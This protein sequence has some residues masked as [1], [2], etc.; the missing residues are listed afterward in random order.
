MK[1]HIHK[2][3]TSISSITAA[4]FLAGIFGNPQAGKQIANAERKTCVPKSVPGDENW[5]VVNPG[6]VGADKTV[7]AVVSKGSNI[8]FGGSFSIIGNTFANN[9]VKWDGST[10]HALGS[11]V[12]CNVSPKADVCALACDNSGNIYAGGRFDIAG[13]ISANHVAKWNGSS[14]SP[15]GSG[16]AGPVTA[17]VCDNSGNLYTN[18]WFDTTGSAYNDYIAKWNGSTWSRLCNGLNDYSYVYALAID[19]S[20]NLYA[21]GVFDSI[22]GMTAR[23]IAKWNGNIWAALGSGLDSSVFALSFDNSGNLYAA[24]FFDSA[25]GVVAKSIAKW[26]GSTWSAFGS[27]MNGPVDAIA[28]DNSNNLYAG[29]L[30]DTAGGVAANRAA[31]WNGSSWTA[32]GSGM[33]KNTYGTFHAFTIDN[34]GNLFAGG[35]F[36]SISG[37]AALN[38]AKWNG[39]AWSAVCVGIGSGRSDYVASM[40]I[41]NSGDLYA[42]GRFPVAATVLAGGIAKWD[43]KNWSALGS[44]FYQSDALVIDNSGNLYAGLHFADFPTGVFEHYLAKWNGNSWSPLGLWKVDYF[45]GLVTDNTGN[46]YAG[47]YFDSA[48]GVVAKNIALWDGSSWSS[49]GS[50]VNL[51]VYALV[52]DNSGNLYTGGWF[53][54]AGGVHARGVAKWDGTTWNSL[55][56]GTS[57]VVYALYFD[58]SGSLYAGGCF[59]TAGSVAA[60]S[61]AKW[62][63]SAWYT[64]GSGLQ[65][66]LDAKARA[67]TIDNSG[68]L[69]AGGRF[70][71]AGSVS[72]NS[73]A[74]WDGKVWSSLGSGVDNCVYALAIDKSNEYLYVGGNFLTAGDKF[75]P[76]L[77]R[78]RLKPTPIINSNKLIP[79]TPLKY[80]AGKLII[81]ASW[82]G[83]IVVE[84][85][86]VSGKRLLRSVVNNG[87]AI[88]LDSVNRPLPAGTYLV[89]CSFAGQA[90]C[91]KI[92]HTW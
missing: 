52:L 14:W 63:G 92:L 61:I 16:T 44:K 72:A 85:F 87:T 59:N 31:K 62:D 22:G 9:I 89:R 4:L 7:L 76:Y 86:T 8:Y 11:G 90:V 40:V 5:E 27:G 32:L 79:N 47:G 71:T 54:S 84:V 23:N 25:G 48:G 6:I 18:G 10:W 24:G 42:G 70:D 56:L 41:N 58:N 17:L 83:R 82:A 91:M 81:P 34:S 46:L 64:L 21:G 69:Y 55:G 1:R 19:N 36:D 67:L 73:I 43:G 28:I 65:G 26:N 13:G 29:G 75:S 88:R 15:L 30:F 50:G 37:I 49:L 51:H 12:G 39:S 45:F 53:D 74:K 80:S 2:I 38:I 77:A 33:N 35:D 20:G 66:E 68:N 57:G 3:F 78:Y 60:N